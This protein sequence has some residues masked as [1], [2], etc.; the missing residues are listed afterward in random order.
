MVLLKFDEINKYQEFKAWLT[1]LKPSELMEEE[2]R[3]K[4]LDWMWELME[5]LYVLG[6]NDAREELGVVAEDMATF[7][8]SDYMDRKWDALYKQYDGLDF[9]DRT[10]I[11]AELGDIQSLL[12]VAETDGHRIYESGGSTGAEGIATT[13]TW[14][15]MDDDRVRDT[16]EYLEERTVGINERFY[17]FDGDSAMFPGDF[18]L[19]QNNVRCRCWTTYNR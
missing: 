9:S 12:R 15:T 19:V 10:K 14:H 13:K 17:T 5:Y 16:H 18:S 1:S 4:S 6:F 8:P 11:Y 2:N 7:L 3:M